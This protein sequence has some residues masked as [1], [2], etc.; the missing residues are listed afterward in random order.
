MC[1]T[2]STTDRPPPCETGHVGKKKIKKK[3]KNDAS[4]GRGPP[5]SK[6][7]GEAG[8]LQPPPSCIAALSAM[9]S[10][11]VPQQWRSRIVSLN[12]TTKSVARSIKG[13]HS[14]IPSG[15]GSVEG[16]KRVREV[17]GT[18]S[19]RCNRSTACRANAHIRAVIG[20]LSDSRAN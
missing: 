14:H 10:A 8:S 13:I 19:K 7:G 18:A 9:P 20:V 16:N 17:R 3:K 6:Q 12:G 2:P 11:V 1:I 5:I 15:G 4:I